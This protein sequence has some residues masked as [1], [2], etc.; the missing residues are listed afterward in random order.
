MSISTR[1]LPTAASAVRMTAPRLLS[2]QYSDSPYPFTKPSPNVAPN[3]FTESSGSGSPYPFTKPDGAAEAT[4]PTAGP[5]RPVS[6][7]GLLALSEEDPVQSP[8]ETMGHKPDY[9]VA[10]DYR[11]SYVAPASISSCSL[12]FPKCIFPST[13]AG[14]GR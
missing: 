11:T 10:A 4:T 3:R 12:I 7:P 14:H 6:G 1:F 9:N 13:I 8:A 5:A 2:R